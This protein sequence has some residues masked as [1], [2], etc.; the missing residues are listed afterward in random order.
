MLGFDDGSE[1]IVSRSYV[2]TLFDAARAVLVH[3]V[4]LVTFPRV[5]GRSDCFNADEVASSCV[6]SYRTEMKLVCARCC[7]LKT[8]TRRK[9]KTN[10]KNRPC[11]G[12]PSILTCV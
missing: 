8:K 2:S 5:G 11:R 4:R 9:T 7:V 3:S 6:L 12:Y 1:S 10:K